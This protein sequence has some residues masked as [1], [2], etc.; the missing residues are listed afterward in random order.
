MAGGDRVIFVAEV[1]FKQISHEGVVFDNQN[2]LHGYPE[3]GYSRVEF[4]KGGL[5]CHH[6]AQ[7]ENE[8]C[9]K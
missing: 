2:L 4:F 8:N 1:S 5:W 7:G 3:L 6:I 9:S